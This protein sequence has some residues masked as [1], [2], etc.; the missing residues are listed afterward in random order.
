MHVDIACHHTTLTEPLRASV[1]QKLA[2]LAHHTDQPI[3]AH[4]VLTV[5]K[6]EHVAEATL[7]VNGA[8]FHARDQAQGMYEAIDGLVGK[9][10]RALRKAKTRRLQ[11]TRG[12]VPSLKQAST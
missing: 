7:S 12:P 8:P 9:L 4:V 5:T 11:R 3:S 1:E 6:H 10:D 2:K